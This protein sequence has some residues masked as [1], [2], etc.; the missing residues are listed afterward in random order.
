MPRTFSTAIQGELDKQY[1]GEP[2]VIVE[3]S[4]NGTSYV[5]YSDRKLSGE[6]YPYPKL[7]SIGKFDTTKVVSG[8][9]DSQ[10]TQIVLDDTDGSIREIIDENDIHLRPVRVYLSFQGLAYSSKAL[11]FEGV[12]NS[13]IDWDEAGRTLT[14]TVFSKLEDNEAGFTMEDGDFPYV[15][16]T[17]RNKPWPLTFGQVCNMEAVRVTALRKG[18]LAQGVGVVDPTIEERLCQ[19]RNL[20]CPTKAETTTVSNSGSNV[21]SIGGNPKD[22]LQ[23]QQCLTDRFNEICTILSEKWAQEQYAIS[24]FTVR[25]GEDFPQGQ[26]ITI[27]IGEVKYDGIM[28]G[29]SFEVR[30]VYHPALET[31]EN[32]PCVEFTGT[33]FGWRYVPGTGLPSTL[34]ECGNGGTEYVKD[35]R[36]GSKES[37]EYYQDFE[38][39]DFI[40]LPPGEDV[41]LEDEADLVYIVSLIPGT[42]NQVAAYR[43]YGDTTLL[44]EVPTDLYTVYTSDFGDYEVVEV[45]L[46]NPLSKIDDADWDDD[47]YVSFTSTVGPNPA[48]TI[49][50]LVNKYTD[51]TVDATSFAAVHA[52]LTNYPS[53]FFV[54]ARPKVLDL[55]RDV[56]YQ[57][58]CAVYIR[59]NVVY[60]KYLSTEPASLK[61]ITESDILTGTFSF[62][63]TETEKLETR[64]KIEWSEGEAAVNQDDETD[65]SF[66]L[67]HNIPKYG[68]F[69]KSYNYYTMNIFELVEKSATFWM[70]RK[71]N[72][73]RRV[74][75]TTTVKHLDL[76]VFDCVTL[77]VSQ[78]PYVKVIIESTDYDADSNTITFTAWTP[79]RSGEDEAYYWAWPSQQ[80]ATAIFPL[81]D[82]QA[83]TGGDGTGLT[84][85]PPVE[86]PLYGGYEADTAYL[87]TDGDKYP[88]DLDDTLPTLVCKLATGAEIADDVEPNIRIPEPKAEAAANERLNDIEA[89]EGTSYDVEWPEERESCGSP[90]YG[91]GCIYEVTVWYI[92]P[93][94]ITTVYTD[95]SGCKAGGPCKTSTG[96][97]VCTGAQSAMCHVFGALFAATAFQSAKRAE[98]QA[99]FD[100]CGYD[101]GVRAILMVGGITANEDPNGGYGS[102]CQDVADIPDPDNPAADKGETQKPVEKT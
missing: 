58:R 92:M 71:A 16:P 4:W 60:L 100:S 31:I 34:E 44:T 99:L 96:G 75:F 83:Q 25:G 17:E 48:D 35:V 5:A 14:F 40:W 18:Y 37:W 72:T 22:G 97:R 24:P 50:W 28:T 52:S 95:A 67:K 70:I 62:T 91:G 47:L 33:G 49:E 19:A 55:I 3:V 102:S 6:D 81:V 73:W 21:V 57:A 98:A 76:D 65:L 63:H 9:S 51:Y 89:A 7:I 23:D 82:E 88:S 84:V 94:L 1:A 39:S 90:T 30:Q 32:P 61:T 42:V 13:S 36:K 26:M 74:K 79:V 15:P 11:M 53:N 93:D 8:G 77:N 46:E 64:H 41:F 12:I 86:H 29:E 66:Y 38:A 54:K 69:D 45:R 59:D 43:T 101:S 85:I 87:A 80:S 27:K 2:L 10:S 78:F 20:L 68:S 56:A